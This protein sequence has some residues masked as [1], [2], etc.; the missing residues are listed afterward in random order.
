MGAEHHHTGTA[1]HDAGPTPIELRVA[2]LEAALVERGLIATDTIE[3]VVHAFE[4]EI[5]PHLG[6]RVVARAWVDPSYRERL[7]D[8]GTAAVAELGIGGAQ[9]AVIR[10][11]EN[12]PEI[13]NVVVCTLCSCYPWPLLG[14]PPTWYKSPAYRARVVREPRSVLAELGLQLPPEVDVRVWDSTS[15]VRYLVL[16][17][18]PEG[19]DAWDEQR[20]AALVG[21]DAMI[22]VALASS[23]DDV[24]VRATP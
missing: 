19:T 14:L 17:Q 9:G 13:H 16:P 22:G 20:L 10:V 7:L 6:A 5:G 15:E 8:E 1:A 4:E 24:A 18:R 2:A 3:A 12:T 23:P 11:V 21:R